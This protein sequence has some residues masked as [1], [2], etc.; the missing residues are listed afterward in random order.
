MANNLDKKWK[1]FPKDL[2]KI[3]AIPDTVSVLVKSSNFIVND[4]NKL[5]IFY[6]VFNSE[7][8]TLHHLRLYTSEWAHTS[9]S[10]LPIN[11][12]T[13]ATAN[14]VFDPYCIEDIEYYLIVG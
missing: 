2:S 14:K 11:I 6:G 12:R 4:F 7:D 1:K 8:G 13:D 10:Y 9:N 3:L 5:G